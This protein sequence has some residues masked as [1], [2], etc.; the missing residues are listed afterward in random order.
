MP[1]KEDSCVTQEAK[2]DDVPEAAP[3]HARGPSWLLKLGLEV[4]LITLGVFFALVA[5]EWREN[6]QHR[7]M[8]AASLRGFRTE[9]VANR[10]AVAS[11][12]DYHVKLLASL[13]AYLAADAAARRLETVQ[14]RGV[15]PVFFEDTAWELALAT[16]SLAHIDPPL[17]FALSRVYRLQRNYTEES[18]GIMQ[19]I[20]LRPLVENFEG[21]VAYY[22]DLVIWEPQLLR[23]YDELLPQIDQALGERPASQAK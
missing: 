8:A 17:A 18:R 3:R 20:F 11:V 5:D 7:E 16:Q 4:A 6:A 21:L 22:G 13:R 23:M 1:A 14:M 9:I 15:Q 10:K 2:E 19:A 12:S